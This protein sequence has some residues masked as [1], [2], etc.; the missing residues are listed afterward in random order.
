[1]ILFGKK[2]L[3]HVVSEYIAHFH[4]ERNHQGLGNVIPSPDNRTRAPGALAGKML[5]A[6]RLGGL[7]K[8]YYR[9]AA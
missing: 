6:E 7:L 9:E 8:F 3:R 1:M 2:S 5:K 4:N